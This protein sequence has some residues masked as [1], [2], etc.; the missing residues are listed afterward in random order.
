[1]PELVIT[2]KEDLAKLEGWTIREAHLEASGVDPVLVLSASHP[3]AA[4]KCLIKISPMIKFGRTGNVMVADG[5]LTIHVED[6]E[7]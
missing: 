2:T 1:M 6:I 4:K 5:L 7:A 3:L